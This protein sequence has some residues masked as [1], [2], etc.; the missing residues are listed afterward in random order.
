LAVRLLRNASETSQKLAD[1]T[2]NSFYITRKWISRDLDAGIYSFHPRA[3]ITHLGGKSVS[4]FPVRLRLKSTAAAIAI[5]ISISAQGARR[6]ASFFPSPRFECGPMAYGC[7]TSEAKEIL[8]RRLEMY[9][10]LFDGRL[11]TQ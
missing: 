6:A 2:S 8:Q 10:K 5:S 9:A 1:S 3:M 7:S 11:L 4:R